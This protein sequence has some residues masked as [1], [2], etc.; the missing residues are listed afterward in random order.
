M[1]QQ[2]REEEGYGADTAGADNAC[3]LKPYFSAFESLTD[4]KPGCNYV[5]PFY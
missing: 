5:S 1:L 3:S 2:Q 4:F